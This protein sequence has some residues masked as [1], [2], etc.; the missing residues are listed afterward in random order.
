M[1]VPKTFLD[2]SF[3]ISD[4]SLFIFFFIGIYYFLHE[5]VSYD[6]I[7]RKINKFNTFYPVQ[8]FQGFYET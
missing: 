2:G 1:S 7:S 5:G 8:D 4:F 3:P 6:I